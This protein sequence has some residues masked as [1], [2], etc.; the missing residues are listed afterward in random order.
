M[1]KL[2]LSLCGWK[3]GADGALNGFNTHR[4]YIIKVSIKIV[5]VH[6]EAGAKSLIGY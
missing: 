1:N 3:T 5:N 2:K 4:C 6:R